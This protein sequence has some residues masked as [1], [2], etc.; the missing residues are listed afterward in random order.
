ME[1]ER[2]GAERRSLRLPP[3][4]LLVLAGEARTAWTHAIPARKSD[5]V[6]GARVARGRR[7]SVTFRTVQL[8]AER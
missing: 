4:S 6:E 2:E 5:V 7:V 8:R 3:R 1:L